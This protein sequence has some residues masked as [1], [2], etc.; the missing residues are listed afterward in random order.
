MK[1]ESIVNYLIIVIGAIITVTQVFDFF[2]ESWFKSFLFGMI[3]SLGVIWL[4]NR[5]NKRK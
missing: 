5:L 4:L 1:N 3:A 2:H